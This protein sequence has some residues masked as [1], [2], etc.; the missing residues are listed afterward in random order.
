MSMHKRR[1]IKIWQRDKFKCFYCDE[2]LKWEYENNYPSPNTRITVEHLMPKSR[3]GTN[4]N[5]NLVTCCRSCNQKQAVKL[6]LGF[7]RIYK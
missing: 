1:K 5:E 3:G 7:T 6:G 4:R 2:D